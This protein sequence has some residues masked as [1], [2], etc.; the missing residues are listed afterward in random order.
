MKFLTKRLNEQDKRK[1]NEKLNVD[2]MEIETAKEL[3]T[4][5]LLRWVVDEYGKN[6]LAKVDKHI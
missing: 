4:L 3:F 5:F 2:V 1:W 6:I